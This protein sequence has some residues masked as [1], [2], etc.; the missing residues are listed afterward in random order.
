MGIQPAVYVVDDE[1]VFQHSFEA[2][3]ATW[4][5]PVRAFSSAE[6]FLADY[7]QEWIG[8]VVVDLRMPGMGGLGLLKELQQRGCSLPALIMTGHGEHELLQQAREYGAVSV[9]EKPYRAEQLKGFLE[10]QFPWV[11][12]R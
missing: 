8:C 3:L 9:L 1:I 2:L 5:I 10:R 6:A 4:G 11:S 12:A 7:Q